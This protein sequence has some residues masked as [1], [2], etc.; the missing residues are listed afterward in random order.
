[1]VKAPWNYT[2]KKTTLYQERNEEKRAEFKKQLELLDPETLVYVDEAGVDNRLF[3]EYGRAPKGQKI[4]ANIPGR[5]RERYSIIAGLIN[6][7]LIAPFTF[8]GGCRAEVF[9][10]WLKHILIPELKPGMTIIL[11]N[12][13]FHKSAETKRLIEEAGCFLLFLPTYSPDFNKIEHW[14]HKVKSLLRPL[15]QKPY[16]SLEKLIWGCLLTC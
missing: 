14:W 12:A 6:K 10:A 1:V 2:K 5:K 3:R 4:L 8:Q 13:A 7:K 11:D 9:N 15:L 16:E